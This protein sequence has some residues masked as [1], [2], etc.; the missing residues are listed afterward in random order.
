MGFESE[1]MAEEII[2]ILIV[3][4]FQ[5]SNQE[6]ELLWQSQRSSI[7]A[8]S[9]IIPANLIPGYDSKWGDYMCKLDVVN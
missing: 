1:I 9:R 4:P 8:A 3:V 5:P 7:S 6:L 2:G